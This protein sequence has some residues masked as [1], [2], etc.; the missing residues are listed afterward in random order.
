VRVEVDAAEVDHPGKASGVPQ[1]HLVGGSPGREPQR[2]RIRSI[3]VC[4]VRGKNTLSGLETGTSRPAT[5]TTA[6]GLAMRSAY[7][8]QAWGRGGVP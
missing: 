7:V 3:F 2:R 4:P 8:G 6:F 5:S 1:H